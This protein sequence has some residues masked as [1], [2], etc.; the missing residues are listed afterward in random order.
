MLKEFLIA[1]SIA[2]L[3]SFACAEDLYIS[4]AMGQS[5]IDLS[6]YDDGTSIELTVGYRAHTNYAFEAS[7]VDLGEFEGN[8][9]PMLTVGYTGINFSFV[10]IIPVND[11]VEV[12]AKIGKYIWDGSIDQAGSGEV[13]GSNSTDTSM[14]IG[15]STNINEKFSLVL[16]YQRFDV[17][18][19]MDPITN[20]SIGG[21]YHF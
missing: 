8:S 17:D 13:A 2:C 10:G 21:R 12:F 16:A 1:S 18:P 5:D 11:D 19:S 6:G 14:G 3:S 7:Y 20:M 4:G 9:S 15:I